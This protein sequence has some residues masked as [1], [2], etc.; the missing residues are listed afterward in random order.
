MKARKWLTNSPEVLQQIPVEDRASTLSLDSNETSTVKTLGVEWQAK[1]DCFKFSCQTPPEP[2]LTKRS[3]LRYLASVFDPLGFL[4]PFIVRGKILLQELWASGF[5]LGR[6]S[7][8]RTERQD[9]GM[10]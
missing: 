2:V 3:F 4:A 6:P 7:E 1:V 9:G 8:S 5:G 10:V